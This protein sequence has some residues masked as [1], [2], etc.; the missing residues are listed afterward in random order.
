M[1]ATITFKIKV[2]RQA[3][4]ACLR[5]IKR[6]V[7]SY[8]DRLVVLEDQ[9]EKL[10]QKQLEAETVKPQPQQ[11]SI[12]DIQ[13]PA[14]NMTDMTE[15]KTDE[16]FIQLRSYRRK[17]INAYLVKEGEDHTHNMYGTPIDQENQDRAHRSKSHLVKVRIDNLTDGIYRFVE[18]G[19]ADNNKTVRGYLKIEKG[20]II[21]ESENLN[22]LIV[23][24][25][26]DRLPELEG[27]KAMVK[28]AMDIREKAIA[29]YK[30]Q[31]LEVP[32]TLTETVSSKWFI[33]NRG[34]L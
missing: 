7:V 9:L 24:D 1:Q 16:R 6:R 5:E 32:A 3:I 14:T 17:G 30:K 15:T 18:A 20:E 29:K 11:L 25:M 33:E 23:G 10:I 22:E 4:A 8:I 13:Q 12:F 31:G 27:T 21:E 19:G 26:A 34:V 28:W 2:L